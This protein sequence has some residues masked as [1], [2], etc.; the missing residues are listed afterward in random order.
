MKAHVLIVW[1]EKGGIC[2]PVANES[3]LPVL[4]EARKIRTDRVVKIGEKLEPVISAQVVSFSGRPRITCRADK[5]RED[6]AAVVAAKAAKAAKAAT[7]KK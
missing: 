1:L 2:A 6:D 3:L 7:A 4:A 5:I